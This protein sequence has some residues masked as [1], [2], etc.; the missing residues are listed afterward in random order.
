MLVYYTFQNNEA[1]SRTLRDQAGERAEPRDGAIVGCTW[2]T[3]RWP[4]K[5]GLE[6]KRV[7][8]RVRFGVAGTLDS[9][10][11]MTWVRID[12]LQNRNNALMMGD[13]WPPGGLHWQIGDNG[14]LVL[15]VQ[16]KR[17]QS[18]AHYDGPDIVTPERLGLWLHLAVTY[19]HLGKQVTHYVDGEPVAKM[20]VLFDIPLVVGDAEI[21][22]W[23]VAT[24]RNDTPI[25]NLHGCMDEFML[26]SRA[27]TDQEVQQVYSESQPAR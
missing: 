19:D 5:E 12:T 26:W 6:F 3:G 23:N 25:R 18:A 24:H 21:G 1:W 7:S 20:P 27:L 4:G 10:T 13:G 14:M 16:G 8:D 15:G 22:N 11:L 2:A 9:L 17:R